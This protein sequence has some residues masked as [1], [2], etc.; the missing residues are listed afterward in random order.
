MQRRFYVIFNPKTEEL[1][2]A[3]TTRTLPALYST[4]GIAAGVLK[5][6]KANN[7]YWSQHWKKDWQVREAVLEVL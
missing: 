5:Q 1:K 2:P 6:L 7:G 3:N 4:Y